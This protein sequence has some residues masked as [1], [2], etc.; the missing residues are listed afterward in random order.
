MKL[1][2]VLLH[3][4]ERSGMFFQ[5]AEFDVAAAFLEGFDTAVNDGALIGFREWL[6]IKL[7]YGNN[8]GWPRLVLYLAFPDTKEP[9][10]QLSTAE[11]KTAMIAMRDLLK[12]FAQD[13]EAPNGLLRI[14]LRYYK[15][16]RNQDWFD[17][18]YPGYFE[19]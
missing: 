12:E 8:L 17:P 14:Y 2:D 13:R 15:W 4:L 9:Q 10:R 19:E 6:I 3:A 1:P 5:P 16:L 18:S 7:G 11:Q